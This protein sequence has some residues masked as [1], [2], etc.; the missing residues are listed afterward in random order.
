MDRY[1]TGGQR[2]AV[3]TAIALVGGSKVVFLDEPTSGMDPFKRRQTWDLLL[4]HKVGR[5]IVLTTHFMDEA[6]L[7]GDRIAIM[8]EGRLRTLGSSQFLKQRFGVGYHLTLVKN[9]ACDTQQVSA[10]IGQYSATAS[11]VSD[12]GSELTYVTPAM[13]ITL[14]PG[15]QSRHFDTQQLRGFASA[16]HKKCPPTPIALKPTPS[17]S[18]THTAVLRAQHHPANT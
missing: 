13:F 8:A 10:R 2:R 9:D 18:Q 15:S 14:F 12:V 11:L 17:Q 6:D 4:K 16:P 7:L 1:G 3:S 5:T